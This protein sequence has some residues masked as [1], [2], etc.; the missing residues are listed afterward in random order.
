[1]QLSLLPDISQV[2]GKVKQQRRKEKKHGKVSKSQKGRRRNGWR[3]GGRD[4][5]SLALGLEEEAEN[6]KESLPAYG[7]FKILLENS[8]I[9]CI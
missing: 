4:G 7:I 6:S 2:F 5:G 8:N 3:S 9:Y 1:M